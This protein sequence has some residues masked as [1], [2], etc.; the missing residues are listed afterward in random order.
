MNW[1][2]QFMDS[3]PNMV[4][5]RHLRA[6]R[7]Y[8]ANLTGAGNFTEAYQR[9]MARVFEDSRTIGWWTAA[10][11]TRD[12]SLCF[13]AAM[14]HYLW[15]HRREDYFWSI[16]DGAYH[17]G[18]GLEHTCP[19][20]RVARHFGGDRS[21]KEG[22]KLGTRRVHLEYSKRALATM[23]AG[24]RGLSLDSPDPLLLE[25]L[26]SAD[27]GPW[28]HLQPSGRTG[29]WHAMVGHWVAPMGP[30]KW[31]IMEVREGLRDQVISSPA[32]ETLTL[33]E[34][35]AAGA[36]ARRFTHEA[37]NSD[38]VVELALKATDRGGIFVE[39]RDRRQ[40]RIFRGY[41]RRLGDTGAHCGDRRLESLLRAYASWD[42]ER[43]AA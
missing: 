4:R 28:K 18:V 36:S 14:Y 2:A 26:T 20:L 6:F 9:A 16:R 22:P 10:A 34:V 3:F 24:E 32:W 8:L 7:G 21:V 12:E 27:A 15:H 1:V 19:S 39:A 37:V 17:E 30:D 23:L 35:A 42:R 33:R 5:P 41:V 25:A 13:Q 29:S 38:G 11:P 40:R 31:I 43:A